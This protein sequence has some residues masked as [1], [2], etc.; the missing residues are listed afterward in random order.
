[1][2]LFGF[3]IVALCNI[4]KQY[5]YFLVAFCNFRVIIEPDHKK[6][7]IIMPAINDRIRELRKSKGL[8]MEQF[9]DV[10][11]LTKAT[12]SRLE[13]GAVS[14]TEQTVKSICR[15]FGVS[16]AW[17]RTGEGP[18][19]DDTSGSILDRLTAEYHLDD[20]KRAILTAFLKLSPADQD[21]ILRYVDGV[22]SELNAQPAAPDLDVDAE[23]EAYRQELLT[24]KKA[25]AAASATAGS[26]AG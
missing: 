22:V 18:M 15:E 26:A 21:A 5:F 20:R 23:V 19:L 12:V 24:Q 11:G 3:I 9:G 8:T 14:A 17:L 16:E 4:V 13:S 6:E 1:M 2:Q 10:I 7:V 25:E